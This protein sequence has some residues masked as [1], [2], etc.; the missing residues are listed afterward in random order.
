MSLVSQHSGLP[1][2]SIYWHFGNK[3]GLLAAVMGHGWK[4]WFEKIP[5]W[6]SMPQ[7]PEERILPWLTEVAQAVAGESEF[8]RFG[9]LLA[10]EKREKEPQARSA[11]LR[12]H[13]EAIAGFADTLKKA[14]EA[15]DLSCSK[16]F[17]HYLATV[18]IALV[19]GTFVERYANPGFQDFS[20][21][22][23]WF[24]LVLASP[25]ETL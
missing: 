14:R 23:N 10:L 20:E 6:E 4:K 8:L 13:Q 17:A 21:S 7:S 3:D 18:F 22:I 11:F 16:D 24:Y 19:N 15:L 9:L 1:S 5:D 12:I 25:T 2:S